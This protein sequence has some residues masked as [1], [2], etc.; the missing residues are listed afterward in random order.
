MENSLTY[1]EWINIKN[2][3][4]KWNDKY[5]PIP[6][7]SISKL[8]KDKGCN[9]IQISDGYGLYHLGKDV[10]DFGV[11]LFN[12]E[13][14]I[15]IRTKIHTRKDKKGFCRLSVILACQPKN[16]KN[17]TPSKYSLDTIDKLPPLLIYKM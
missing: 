16:I 9:Y 4:N 5:I 15:R 1:E 12:I 8:Y 13:Q 10:C 6:S 17:L 14:Q 2:K 3:T 7:D 11:P